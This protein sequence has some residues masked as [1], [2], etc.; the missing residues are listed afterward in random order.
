MSP[1]SNNDKNNSSIKKYLPILSLTILTISLLIYFGLEQF[2]KSTETNKNNLLSDLYSKTLKPIFASKQ[3]TKE[4]VLNFAL[5]NNLPIDKKENKILEVKDDPSGN[6][7]IE[8]R[9]ASIKKST[10]NYS[11]F[12]KKMELNGKQKNELDSLLEEFKQTITNTIFSDDQKTLAVDAR[13]G[14]LHRILRTEIFDFISRVKVRENVVQVYTE[15]TL[16]NFN[17]IIAK[18][19]NKS[20]RNYIFFTPDTVIQSEAEFVRGKSSQPLN[21]EEPSVFMPVLNVIRKNGNG[22]DIVKNGNGFNF[23]IDSN[24]IKVILTD[25][26]LEDLDIDNYT[27]LKS[28]LDTSSS[29]FEFSIG[30]PDEESMKLSISASNPDSNDEFHY[31]FNLNDLGELINSSVQIPSNSQIEDWVEFG[32]GMDSLAIRLHE[33]SFDTLDS[34]KYE[35]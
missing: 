30:V 25:D 34:I 10:D 2:D 17:K 29:R 5:Y 26:F 20:V 23:K 7:V 28:V 6:E 22:K 11:K 18:E 4:D 15:R 8:V 12:I 1:D 14:L 27:E 3:L 16:A 31:E 13:I 19:R 9:K 24:F 33:L 35:D 21:K 32:I